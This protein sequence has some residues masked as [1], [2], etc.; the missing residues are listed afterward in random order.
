[1]DTSLVSFYS[2]ISDP[3]F[4]GTYM[5][6][7]NAFGNLGK[8]IPTTFGLKLI[9]F[10][11]RS[12]CSIETLNRCDTLSSRNVRHFFRCILFYRYLLY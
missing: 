2:Q 1:M 11:T 8:E 12:K 3:R 6:L 10:L 9:G 4:G 5:T 7:L